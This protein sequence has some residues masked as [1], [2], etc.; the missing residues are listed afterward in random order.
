MAGSKQKG[1]RSFTNDRDRNVRHGKDIAAVR[2]CSGK[3]VDCRLRVESG[4]QPMHIANV[5]DVIDLA[6]LGAI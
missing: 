5:I 2:P 4:T 1:D 6:T 3:V